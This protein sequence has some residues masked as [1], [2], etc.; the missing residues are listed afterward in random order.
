MKLRQTQYVYGFFRE[1]PGVLLGL[2]KQ[3]LG[4]GFLKG[5]G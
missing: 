1:R 3:S 2:W 4:A 5:M